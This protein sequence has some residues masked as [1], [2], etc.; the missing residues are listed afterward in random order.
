MKQLYRVCK[1]LQTYFVKTPR[2]PWGQ[3]SADNCPVNRTVLVPRT[4]Q[5]RLLRLLQKFMSEKKK[6]PT[7]CPIWS[8]NEQP[9][10]RISASNFPLFLSLSFTRKTPKVQANKVNLKI[11]FW[12]QLV[13]MWESWKSAANEIKFLKCENRRLVLNLLRTLTPILSVTCEV[14]FLCGDQIK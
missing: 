10:L 6:L 1:I 12:Q 13:E 14:K 8:P 11:H 4:W 5:K 2:L 3:T 9:P 7:G